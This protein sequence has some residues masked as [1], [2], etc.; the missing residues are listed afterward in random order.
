MM[1]SRRENVVYREKG[2]T[3]CFFKPHHLK[4]SDQLYL[5]TGEC[6]A[7]QA[8]EFNPDS[9]DM[10]ICFPVKPFNLYKDSLNWR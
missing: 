2:T 4:K 10:L 3:S 1:Y 6:S 8:C 5:Q 7:K 9:Y